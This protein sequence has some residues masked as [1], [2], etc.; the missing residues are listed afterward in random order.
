MTPELL[1]AEI[2]KCEHD[3]E[4]HRLNVAIERKIERMRELNEEATDVY[5]DWL[6]L[7]NQ[8]NELM[9]KIVHKGRL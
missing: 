3:I 7:Y 1:L 5:R 8:R 9:G 2:E 6:K 4:L